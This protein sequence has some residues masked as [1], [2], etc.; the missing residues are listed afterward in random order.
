MS[1]KFVCVRVGVL[2][3]YVVLNIHTDP[4]RVVNVSR[5]IGGFCVYGVV[6]YVWGIYLI[7]VGCGC[8]FDG[9]SY[10]DCVSHG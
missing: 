4:C 7:R 1:W 3:L 5:R 9:M 2:G 8:F 6:V 10:D